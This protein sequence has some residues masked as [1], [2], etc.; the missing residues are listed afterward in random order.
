MNTETLTHQGRPIALPGVCARVF[1][2]MPANFLRTPEGGTLG[3]AEL[4]DGDAV[5]LGLA[6]ARQTVSHWRDKWL[7]AQRL[8]A[9]E[10]EEVPE[11]SLVHPA[12]VEKVARDFT[13][14]TS[15]MKWHLLSP[16]TQDATRAQVATLLTLFLEEIARG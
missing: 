14:A 15:P 5:L 9:R 7:D 2:P 10:A 4:T 16:E 8:N 3:L 11:P 6:L 1:L 13:E 12:L